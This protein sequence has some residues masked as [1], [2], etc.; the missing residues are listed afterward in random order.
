[1]SPKKTGNE[2]FVR[3]P[4]IEFQSSS[5]L[6]PQFDA[7][8]K[9]A[10]KWLADFCK[11]HGYTKFEFHRNHFDFSGFFKDQLWYFSSGDVRANF[12]NSMLIHTA[13]H[14]K[15]WH[16]G[17]NRFAQYDVN[18]EVSIVQVVEHVAFMV[19]Q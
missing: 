15:D 3:L 7:F 13:A 17:Q 4:D 14:N 11:R 19:I 1:M 18:F 9:E 12:M 10:K 16:G 6:T 5:G 2:W 8:Q